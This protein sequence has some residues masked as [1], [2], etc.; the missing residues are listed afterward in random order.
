MQSALAD[1]FPREL[2]AYAVKINDVESWTFGTTG[3]EIAAQMTEQARRVRAGRGRFVELRNA[4]GA[5]L[6]PDPNRSPIPG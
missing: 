6:R 1:V 2:L 4:P 5:A 3:I